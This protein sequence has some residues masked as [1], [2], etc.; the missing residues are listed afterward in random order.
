MIRRILGGIAAV[1]VIGVGALLLFGEPALPK[2][3]ASNA[4]STLSEIVVNVAGVTGDEQA[5]AAARK[6]VVLTD[7]TE[8]S[9][10]KE[11]QIR[12]CTGRVSLSVD[13]KDYFK[14]VG[15][16]YRI[17]WKDREERTFQ[18]RTRTL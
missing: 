8:A 13:G 15:I 3:D 7:L 9:F 6:A 4:K 18:I 11:A 16:G 1:V 14:D 12:E 10:D 17:D 2:C 5:I